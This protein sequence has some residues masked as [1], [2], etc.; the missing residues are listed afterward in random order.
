MDD[1]RDPTALLHGFPDS[2]VLSKSITEHLLID[3]RGF[4]PLAIVRPAVIGMF[5]D[6]HGQSTDVSIPV[7]KLESQL[8]LFFHTPKV[9]YNY[10][11]FHFSLV[12]VQRTETNARAASRIV[13]WMF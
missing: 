2:Y 3:K 12:K 8:A 7:H 6:T 5:P 13:K 10:F 4:L 9:A 1:D 11:W